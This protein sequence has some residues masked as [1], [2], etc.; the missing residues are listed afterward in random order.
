MNGEEGYEEYM[1]SILKFKVPL[2]YSLRAQ[3]ARAIYGM[4]KEKEAA[5]KRGKTK[6]EA[7]IY[8]SQYIFGSK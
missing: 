1:T 2:L 3:F 5:L 4:A 7:N 6:K 8:I